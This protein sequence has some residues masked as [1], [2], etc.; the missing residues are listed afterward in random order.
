[1]NLKWLKAGSKTLWI[2]V[3]LMVIFAAFL[4]FSPQNVTSG[5]STEEKRIAQVLSAIAGAGKVDVALFYGQNDTGAFGE[6]SRAPIG[7]VIVASGAD[8]IEVRLNLI[9]AARTLL[10]LPESAVDVF[11]MEDR[12]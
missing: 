11:V 3:A 10:C 7:A 12:Q 4:L 2:T 5:A 1:M 9:R 6:T 8:D